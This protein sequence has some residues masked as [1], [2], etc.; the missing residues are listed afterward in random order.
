MWAFSVSEKS[1]NPHARVSDQFSSGASFSLSTVRQEIWEQRRENPQELSEG[2]P[3]ISEWLELQLC[4]LN[5]SKGRSL[6]SES[7]HSATKWAFGFMR[8][9]AEGLRTVSYSSG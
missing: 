7:V 3:T 6:F 5:Y 9:N 4:L 2:S 8:D 1:N